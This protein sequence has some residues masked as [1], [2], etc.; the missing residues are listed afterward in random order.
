MKVIGGP[1]RQILNTMN[2]FSGGGHNKGGLQ[3][4][5]GIYP[6]SGLGKGPGK[7]GGLSPQTRAHCLFGAHLGAGG[8][9]TTVTGASISRKAQEVQYFPH[10]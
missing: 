6:Y 3:G 1:H 8:W 5:E 7:G 9:K 10:H 2:T 4:L